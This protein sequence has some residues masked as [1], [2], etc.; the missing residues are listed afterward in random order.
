M[1]LKKV[2]GR[3][4]GS[5]AGNYATGVTTIAVAILCAFLVIYRQN[6]PNAQPVNAPLTEFSSGRAMKHLRVIARKPHPIGSAEH[7]E[8]RDYILKELSGLGLRSEVQRSFVLSQRRS[9]SYV[10]ASVENVIGIIKG[11]DSRRSILFV[12]HYDSTPN[13]PG[14]SDDGAGVAALLEVIRA[15]KTGAPLKNDLL[16]LFTDGE[17]VGMLGAKAFMDEDPRAKDVAVALNFEARGV[18]GPS[19]MFETSEGNEWLIQ[20]FAKAVQRPVANSLTSDLYKLLPNDTDLTIFKNG[21]LRGFNFAYITGLSSY[22]TASDNYENIDE[23]SLQHH[24]SYALSLARRFGDVTDWQAGEGNAVYFD[25]FSSALVSYSVRFVQ[26]LMALGLACLIMAVIL[27]LRARRLTVRGIAFGAGCFLLNIISVGLIVMVAWQAIQRVSL[28]PTGG[29]NDGPYATGFLLLTI[30][31][32]SSLLA[33]SRKKTR[34]ENLIVSASLWWA[35]LMVLVCLSA[36]GGSYLFT[37]PLLLMA[38]ALGAV[39]I[40][41]A[42]VRSAKSVIVLTLPALAS[43]ILIAPLMNLMIAG[44]G[45]QVVWILMA[46]A[47]FILAPHYAHL[48]LFMAIK[49]WRLPAAS[50]LLGLCFVVFA[51]LMTDLSVTHP[52]SDHIFY[53]LN[54]D[55]G[56]AIW[57]SADQ[58]P[59]EW[60]A[61]FFS[62]GAEKAGMAEQFPWGRGAFLKSGAMALPLPPPS[63]LVIGDKTEDGLRTLRLRVV[64]PRR[65]PVISIYW[66]GELAL[67]SVAVNGKR[68]VKQTPDAASPAPMYRSVSYNGLP[69]GGFELSLEIR[70]SDPVDLKVEDRSHGLPEIPGKPYTG[71]PNYIVA[72]PAQYSDCT[73]VARSVKF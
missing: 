60:T 5:S 23:G 21:G 6:P 34:V 37:W 30:A 59:D 61:Q 65:A 18:G 57:G 1:E 64:S 58:K 31:L 50:G 14:A 32:T 46:F 67:E 38:L 11:A 39:F 48:N 41:G 70:S 66:K 44:F 35:I 47:A 43:I 69:E 22:H 4:D 73:V 12:S 10:A 51:L 27:G 3:D 7:S 16:F 8:V 2:E 9:G 45:M 40:S 24:G 29:N 62:S 72:A 54:A 55:T 33:W 26:P 49:S 19:I 15:L 63:V 17:E 56:G 42:E 28:N 71:R 68:V 52:K 25:V 53:A 20:E 13:S 36:P